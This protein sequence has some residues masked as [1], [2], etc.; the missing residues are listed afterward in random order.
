M[1][2]TSG[3]TLTRA[4]DF[5]LCASSLCTCK[6]AFPKCTLT[7][8]TGRYGLYV[9]RLGEENAN[10][11]LYNWQ[12]FDKRNRLCHNMIMEHFEVHKEKL[13]DL[14]ID[15]DKHGSKVFSDIPEHE[16]IDALT[17][18]DFAIIDEMSGLNGFLDNFLMSR[19]IPETVKDRIRARMVRYSGDKPKEIA[20]NEMRI[21]LFGDQR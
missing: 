1:T 6:L 9:N 4:Q 20:L 21:K 18:D 13:E 3:D 8:V 16:R 2:T 11:L 17:L 19:E 5:P 15:L 12:Y 7:S 10:H 14:L